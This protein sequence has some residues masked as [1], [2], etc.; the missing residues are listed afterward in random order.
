MR[1][2]QAALAI[3]AVLL[4][5][6]S[7]LVAQTEVYES[8]YRAA[9]ADSVITTDEQQIL[10]AIRNTLELE[11]DIVVEI[12]RQVAAAPTSG[13]TFSRAGR[14]AIIAQN[15]MLANGLYGWGL[16]Y[17]LGIAN[18]P[19]VVGLELLALGG[20]FYFS[21]QYTEKIDL[22]EARATFQNIG[23]LAAMASIYPLMGLVGFDRWAKMDPD[24]KLTVSYL[25]VSIPFGIIW[26]D[27]LYRRWQPSDGQ[28]SAVVSAGLAAGFNAMVGQILLTDNMDDVGEDW[29][30]L[31]SLL[32][33]GGFIGGGYLGWKYL[34]RYSITTGD[35]Y[36]YSFG[37][38]MG[39]LTG[40]QL[41]FL[42][43]SRFK[44]GLL[45]VTASI[46]AGIYAA[47]KLSAPYDMTVGETA[48]ISLGS[49]A[50]WASFRGITFILNL[51]QSATIF[52]VGD[53]LARLGGAWYTFHRIEPRRV[54]LG[55]RQTTG[56][57]SFSPIV[58]PSPRGPVPGLNLGISF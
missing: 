36:F 53:I 17:V 55:A 56:R 28:A 13:I 31:N 2:I 46:D 14:R 16:P 30:R 9:F 35:S 42:L 34:N 47:L 6:S 38:T 21:W 44:E 20:G 12:H 25:M 48:I 27:R 50:G 7:R 1:A 11:E 58:L 40:L 19:V 4:V 57:L 32:V 24:G 51:D 33:S 8:A 18:A 22:P 45:L 3:I 52:V 10:T 41:A 49:M 43:D 37:A 29:L 23:S 26:S 54:A 5:V 39:Y 15:M